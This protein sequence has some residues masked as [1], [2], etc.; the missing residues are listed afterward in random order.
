MSG[1]TLNQYLLH[2]P[3]LQEMRPLHLHIYSCHV[4]TG[5]HFFRPKLYQLL[6]RVSTGNCSLHQDSKDLMPTNN[7]TI[8]HIVSKSPSIHSGITQK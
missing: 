3:R 6:N 5:G 8:T 2:Y 1:N 4:G 7:K